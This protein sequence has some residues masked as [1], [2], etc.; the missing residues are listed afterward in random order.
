VATRISYWWISRGIFSFKKIWQG[1]GAPKVIFLLVSSF[2]FFIR[3]HLMLCRNSCRA[4]ALI[5]PCEE[6][7]IEFP[8]KLETLFKEANCL[9]PNVGAC[10][11]LF[12]GVDGL[13]PLFNNS[14]S[15]DVA[16]KRNKKKGVSIFIGCKNI[17]FGNRPYWPLE[18][19]RCVLWSD[20]PMNGWIDFSRNAK[21]IE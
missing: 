13:L 18:R 19:W 11:A 8:V 16:W 21:R 1:R 20:C 7:A 9:L 4:A 15:A 2:R 10:L 14:F 12:T 6:P 17:V 3:F 5:V